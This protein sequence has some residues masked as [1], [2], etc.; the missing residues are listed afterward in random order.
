MGLTTSRERAYLDNIHVTLWHADQREEAQ[1]EEGW[2]ATFSFTLWANDTWM[3][4]LRGCPLEKLHLTLEEAPGRS[5]MFQILG[6]L[7]RQSLETTMRIRDQ[8]VV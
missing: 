1:V 5:I 7:P 3:P 8:A 2:G 6:A 4:F